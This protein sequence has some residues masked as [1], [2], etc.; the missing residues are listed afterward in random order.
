MPAKLLQQVVHGNSK[1][2][3]PSCST[4]PEQRQLPGQP[5]QQGLPEQP[6]EARAEQAP[7][8]LHEE[9]DKAYAWPD[10]ITV[11][12]S[13]E[14]GT[15]R[16]SQ[17][18]TTQPSPLMSDKHNLFH[19]QNAAPDA[20]GLQAS[21][22]DAAG[23]SQQV[24]EQLPAQARHIGSRPTSRI[25]SARSHHSPDKPNT[26][27]L[28]STEAP[29][30]A[31]HAV[32][33]PAVGPAVDSSASGDLAQALASCQNGYDSPSPQVGV[34]D[35]ACDSPP[36]PAV[37]AAAVSSSMRERL[38]ERDKSGVADLGQ[39]EPA[40]ADPSDSPRRPKPADTDPA[41]T[42]KRAK[43]AA[44]AALA[45]RRDHM[46]GRVSSSSQ[47]QLQFHAGSIPP[48]PEV[49]KTM[50]RHS[51]AAGSLLSSVDPEP[52]S[53]AS[54]SFAVTDRQ[55]VLSKPPSR[56]SSAGSFAGTPAQEEEESKASNGQG[57]ASGQGSAARLG[58]SSA[59]PQLAPAGSSSFAVTNGQQDLS[60]P[61]S[62]H[63]SALSSFTVTAEQPRASMVSS[64]AAGSRASSGRRQQPT[65]STDTLPEVA[66]AQSPVQ[67]I[68]RQTSAT[69]SRAS[70]GKRDQQTALAD[71]LP[72]VAIA[73]SP[74][75]SS[76]R[77]SS[78]ARSRA[79][80]GRKQQLTVSAD[81]L[82]GIAAVQNSSSAISRQSS[83]AISQ[84]GFSIHQQ[85][86]ASVNSLLDIAA[87]QGE[88]MSISRQ[89]STVRS[90]ANS[91]SRNQQTA[92]ADGLPVIA[93]A[94]DPASS[95]SRISSAGKSRASS[96]R[97][98]QQLASVNSLPGIPVESDLP[99]DALGVS[100]LQL[101]TA[102]SHMQQSTPSRGVDEALLPQLSTYAQQV[103][104]SDQHLSG[105]SASQLSSTDLQVQH[106]DSPTDTLRASPLQLSTA[107]PE[108][109]QSGLSR[110]V[111][112]A[113]LAQLGK[114][115][116]AGVVRHSVVLGPPALQ[117][118][119]NTQGGVSPLD[120]AKLKTNLQVKPPTILQ[121]ALMSCQ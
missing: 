20:G 28:P 65:M 6:S 22:D 48:S 46:L 41:A 17:A 30:S 35:A 4:D 115:G 71:S 16:Q 98:Q 111:V 108:L 75:T 51:S 50:S 95:V 37:D 90:R 9:E 80:S 99:T 10:D 96:G 1:I 58:A 88:R 19:T 116:G 60:Q 101:S 72:E 92:S 52:R 83:A 76:S 25:S 74:V 89:S 21:T 27:G 73:H 87:A 42:P 81:S 26:A 12:T 118:M 121:A 15:S 63:S 54:D 45:A 13:V 57:R 23:P 44:L 43:H 93:A 14:E 114:E 79:S 68:S 100:P 110:D 24:Y 36:G 55:Q 31:K 106:L 56:H 70:S 117:L 78:A 104:Q 105:T 94:Q 84:A 49:A 5:S 69:R 86:T 2:S 97:Q 39:A 82:P 7:L 59:A 103:Q 18:S 47:E 8:K 67:G 112:G 119:P 3:S 53:T 66:M 40:N 113:S 61:P 107:D 91:S 11:R 38:A 85:R 120:Y 77:Q 33:A 32:D 34:T 64:S 29:A 102:A 62:K 109:P